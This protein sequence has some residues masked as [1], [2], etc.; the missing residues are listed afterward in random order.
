MGKDCCNSD[1]AEKVGQDKEYQDFLQV[2]DEEAGTYTMSNG[3]KPTEAAGTVLAQ[4]MPFKV[5]E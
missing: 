2:Y 1:K 5:K 3:G 4:P